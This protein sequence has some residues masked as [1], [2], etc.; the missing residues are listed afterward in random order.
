M[1]QAER[2]KHKSI[3]TDREDYGFDTLMLC[4]Q[5]T[6]NMETKLTNKIVVNYV[7]KIKA[8]TEWVDKQ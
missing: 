7:T 5:F 6:N 4:A 3:R 1:V 2:G 8:P